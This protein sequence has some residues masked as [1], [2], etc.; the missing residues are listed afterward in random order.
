MLF[1]FSFCESELS[2]HP[3]TGVIACNDQAAAT[4]IAV[5]ARVSPAGLTSMGISFV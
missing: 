5:A 4:N 1:R 3:S 2:V